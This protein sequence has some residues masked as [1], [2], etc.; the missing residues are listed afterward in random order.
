MEFGRGPHRYDVHIHCSEWNTDLPGGDGLTE[1]S[2][3]VGYD[4][5]VEEVGISLGDMRLF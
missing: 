1:Q 2:A 4:F 3:F 5:N